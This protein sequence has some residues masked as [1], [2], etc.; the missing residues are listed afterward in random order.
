M[1]TYTGYIGER[2]QQNLG[3]WKTKWRFPIA[4]TADQTLTTNQYTESGQTC[5]YYTT[6]RPV[7][8]LAATE[9][10]V[11]IQFSNYG[12]FAGGAGWYN[13]ED[14]YAMERGDTGTVAA[15]LCYG[16]GQTAVSPIKFADISVVCP[17]Y[18]QPTTAYTV[19]NAQALAGKTLEIYIDGP[20]SIWLRGECT[21]TITTAY[22][23]S[24]CGAPSNVH[25]TNP[26]SGYSTLSWDAGS[27]GTNNTLS[28]YNYE[29]RTSEDRTNWT[30]WMTEGIV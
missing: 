11:S 3:W 14:G 16:S 25:V 18:A 1:P 22:T 9:Y 21:V 24:K 23:Y 28:T 5:A 2:N 26:V 10:P 29:Y 8:T 30:A 13:N 12:S 6:N 20:R 17:Q 7:L 15:Y 4:T 27:S 19:P